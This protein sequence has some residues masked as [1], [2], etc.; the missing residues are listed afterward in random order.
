V[1]FTP[2]GTRLISAAVDGT[3]RL[4]D[5]AT[6][7]DLGP[8]E[9]AGRHVW[10]LAISPGSDDWTVKLWDVA[11]GQERATLRGPASPVWSVAVSPDGKA[12]AAGT[13]DGAIIIWRAASGPETEPKR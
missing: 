2:D 6:G 9:Q 3:V 8:F 10:S 12:V 13:G 11:T 4:W 5:A 1:V 7:S